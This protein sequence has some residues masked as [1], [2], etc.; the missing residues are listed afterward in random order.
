M[1]T[2]ITNRTVS[3]TVLYADRAEASPQFVVKGQEI[4][5]YQSFYVKKRTVSPGGTSILFH[6]Q[7]YLVNG[8]C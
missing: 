6:F 2:G 1:N 7:P 3:F 4:I 8:L 5:S